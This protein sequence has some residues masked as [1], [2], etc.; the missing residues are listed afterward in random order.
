MSRLNRHLSRLAAALL[1]LGALL[2]PRLL[3]AQAL[4]GSIVGTV[5]DES[6]APVPGAT[7]VATNTG[8]SLK[9]EAVTDTEGSYTFRNL[10][11]GVYELAI[12][13]QGFRE[14]RQTNVRVSAGNPIRHDLKLEVGAMAETVNVVS[15]STILQ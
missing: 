12:S 15:E 14:L 11:P 7:V 1:A 6:G 10:P 2:A 4:Y 3:C 8:T 13:M 9:V 5:A